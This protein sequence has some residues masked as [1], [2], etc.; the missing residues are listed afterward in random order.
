VGNLRCLAIHAP[1]STRPCRGWLLGSNLLILCIASNA[2]AVF[3]SVGKSSVYVGRMKSRIRF[4][5]FLVTCPLLLPQLV[6]GNRL[7]NANSRSILATVTA[8]TSSRRSITASGTGVSEGVLAC[9]RKYPFG[10]RFKI[11]GKVYKC[12]DRPSAKYDNRFDIWKPT[13][14]AARKFGKRKIAVVL[15][16]KP[17][18]QAG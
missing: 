6:L 10:T 9:P 11:E 5:I 17:R 3:C 1:S 7:A 8:Y 16:S 18:S 13:R 2:S 14:V 12:Q 15:V 4:Y